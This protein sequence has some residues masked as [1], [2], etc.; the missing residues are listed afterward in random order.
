MI[1]S[2]TLTSDTKEAII[3]DALR[4]NL[5]QVDRFLVVHLVDD[6]KAPDRTLQV[7][8]EVAKGKLWISDISM[9]GGMSVWRN[10]GL[11]AAANLPGAAPGDY[12]VVTDT[13][14]R[15]AWNGLDL[16]AFLSQADPTVQAWDICSTTGT[17]TKGKVC[18]S[19]AA[20]EDQSTKNLGSRNA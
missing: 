7:A 19:R 16:R 17:Y 15:M 5:D 9:D 4:S 10:K 2:V 14:E 12:A 11:L 13:D 8:D 1:I 18:R 3:A 20:T 6:S